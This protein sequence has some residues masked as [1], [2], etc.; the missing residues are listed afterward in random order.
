MPRGVKFAVPTIANGKVYVGGQ[1]G[2]SVFGIFSDPSTNPPTPGHY[3]G[4]FY[5]SGGV[6]FLKSGFFAATIARRGAYTGLLQMGTNRYSLN[7]HF[8]S[9][10]SASNTIPRK[11]LNPLNL[12]LHKTQD[13]LFGTVSDGTW[14]ADLL[15]NR[16]TF[17]VRTNPAP[18]APKYTLI[19]PGPADGNPATPQGDGFGTLTN[20]RAGL[21]QITGALGDGTKFTRVAYLS[22]N[23]QWPLYVPLY[24]GPGQILGWL[25]LASTDQ[26]DL[27][28]QISWIKPKTSSRF[29]PDGFDLQPTVTGS[30]YRRPTAGARILNLSG[31][32]IS[33]TDGDLSSPIIEPVTLTSQ[34]KVS[35]NNNLTISFNT[36]SGRFTG[37]IVNPSSGKAI[38][39]NG[40]AL[41]KQN[42]ASGSF[43]GASHSG[44]V[45]IQ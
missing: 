8:D 28:G 4:L 38:V 30:I 14:T 20:N 31:A 39:L 24:G 3:T 33:M 29:Y 19:I 32:S 36:S 6:E 41:Q 44:R 12:Q 27:S 43:L 42:I 40:V 16:L 11:N 23:G 10:G 17:Q 26:D 13:A 7:G 37:K 35:G 25:T 45:R 34:N 15:A 9:T 5:E 18:F 2:V 1:Y 21:I 22:Q